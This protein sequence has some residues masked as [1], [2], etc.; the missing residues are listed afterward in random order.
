VKGAYWDHEVVTSGLV[1]YACPVFT[2][3]ADTDAQYERLTAIMLQNI[4]H[5]LPAIGS[6]NLRS[7]TH[8]LVL[9]RRMKVPANAYEIQMLYGM[10]EPE[11][12]ALRSLGQRVRL[13][14]PIGELLPGMAYLVRRLLENT[15]NSS[16]LRLSHHEGTDIHQLLARPRLS[17]EMNDDGWPAEPK[18]TGTAP[19]THDSIDGE[20]L[21]QWK[22]Q[23]V[24]PARMR[25]GD[26]STPFE[27]CPHTDFT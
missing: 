19:T 4:D 14:T 20:P 17:S 16:F 24:R 11:R 18:A 26:L 5:V 10:A 2:D 7:L 21:G 23:V 8:A 15:A 12:A 13:Y 1:G 25:P 3:K 27:N 6:H 9:A 22:S